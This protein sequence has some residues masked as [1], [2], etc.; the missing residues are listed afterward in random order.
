MTPCLGR[1]RDKVIVIG[2]PGAGK[3]TFSRK[4]RAATGLPLHHLDMIFHRPD[5]TTI[6]REEF[7]RKLG[8]LL[9]GERWIIDGNYWRT[10]SQRLA[11][12]EQVFFFDL[13]LATCL[14]GAEKRVGAPRGDLPWFEEEMDPAFRQYIVDFP[15]EQLPKI[16]SLLAANAS[17]KTIIVFKSHAEADGFLAGLG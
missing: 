16:K 7:D 10:L 3:S 14:A 9:A 11:A 17:T 5:K 6:S 15:R 4:L 8:T 13:P 1:V 12:A 2:C